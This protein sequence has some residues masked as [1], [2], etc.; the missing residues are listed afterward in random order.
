M[1][2]IIKIATIIVCMVFIYSSNQTITNVRKF[3]YEKTK[4]VYDWSV[5]KALSAIEN[6]EKV[7]DI[8]K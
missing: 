8:V 5:G 3:T 6:N 4:I 7:A 1:K 2:T